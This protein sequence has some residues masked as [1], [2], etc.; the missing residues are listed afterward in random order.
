MKT[1]THW[2]DLIFEAALKVEDPSGRRLFLDQACVGDAGLR[3]AVEEMLADQAEADRYFTE[4]SKALRISAESLQAS[5]GESHLE[6]DSRVKLPEDEQIG[7]RIGRYKIVE[8]I[9]EGGC[10]RVYLAE[11]EEP[12]RR[13]VALKIIKLGMDTQSLV[14]RFEAERQVLALMDHPNIARALD[15]GATGTGRP[16]FVMELVRGE[17]ITNYCDQ[18]RLDIRRRLELFIQICHAI[19]HAHQKGIIHRDIKPSNILVTMLDGGA[20]PKVI[21]FGIAKAIT[22]ERLADNTVFTVCEQF[23]GTPAYMSPE[24]AQMGG[25]DIDTRSDI[26]SLGVLLYE[27]L[28]GRTPF[29]GKKLLESSM[30]ELQRTLREEEPA[31]PSVML[32]A[33]ARE[34]R[35]AI[36]SARGL[37][38][39]RLAGLVRDDL[40]W[41][42]MKAL[43][44]DRVRRYETAHEMALDIGRYLN[45]EAVLASPPGRIYLLRKMIRRNKGAFAAVGAVTVTLLLGFGT[46]SVMYLRERSARQEAEFEKNLEAVLRVREQ[47]VHHI[48]EAAYDID[49]GKFE[50]AADQIRS[51]SLENISPSKE[52]GQVYRGVGAWYAIHAKWTDAV[53]FFD[54][55]L[56]INHFRNYF[57]ADA[58]WDDLEA[59]VSILEG[60]NDSHAYEDFRQIAIERSASTTDPLAAERLLRAAL[61]L[62]AP[63]EAQQ[64]LE[65][66]ARVVEASLHGTITN[67]GFVGD[68]PWRPVALAL[69]DLRCGRSQ[70]AIERCQN[71]LASDTNNPARTACVGVILTLSTQ[72]IGNVNEARRLVQPAREAIETRFSK[73]LTAGNEQEGFWFDWAMAQVLLREWE[74]A[75]KRPSP[76][77]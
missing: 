18:H 20:V 8:R 5:N 33:L 55:L 31:R 22:G 39:D 75:A 14:A 1:D 41:I 70:A 43:E 61:L 13:S 24:Q 42:A 45:G 57:T 29:D 2:E 11:Q 64:A 12:V 15:A 49:A 19:Q 21:D 51:I 53:L 56:Q 23:L 35:A 34:Q 72:H 6:G 30:E 37:E 47:S 77:G 68:A 27:L 38:A 59:G 48:S 46:S 58:I 7:S 74:G 40:D 26:Y 76:G 71:L 73:G 50:D 62:P 52:A 36:A 10:G 66:P 67:T 63:I 69:M 32:A 28:T 3:A 65:A 44:K 54:G 60:G 16:Y 9:G 25:M 17:K 4:G